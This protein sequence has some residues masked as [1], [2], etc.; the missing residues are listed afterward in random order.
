MTKRLYAIFT[1]RVT[2]V[3]FRFTTLE[4][5]KSLEIVGWVRNTP[6]GDVELLAEAEK[7]KLEELLNRLQKTFQENIDRVSVDWEEPLGEFRSFY[8][9]YGPVQD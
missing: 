1:G 5:A 6:Q 8:I 3:G 7:S 9:Q 4:I 2:G